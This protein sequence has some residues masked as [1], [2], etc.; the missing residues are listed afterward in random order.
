MPIESFARFR[1]LEEYSLDKWIPYNMWAS[2]IYWKDS[3]KSNEFADKAALVYY[4]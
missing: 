2:V 4:S 3:I 1:L